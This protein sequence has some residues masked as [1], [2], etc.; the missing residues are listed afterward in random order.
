[1]TVKLMNSPLWFSPYEPRRTK[2]SNISSVTYNLSGNLFLTLKHSLIFHF[3]PHFFA[4][5][6]C[7]GTQQQC[8][9][10]LSVLLCDFLPVTQPCP[11]KHG[12]QDTGKRYSAP[13]PQKKTNKKKTKQT[14]ILNL[15]LHCTI[16]VCRW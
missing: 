5:A 2:G 7:F 6:C 16:N 15:L 14:L 4:G 13:P 9:Q 10:L 8:G 3:F 12:W 11:G 1:M